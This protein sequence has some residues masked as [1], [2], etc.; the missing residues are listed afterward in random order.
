MPIMTKSIDYIN[1]ILDLA[2]ALPETIRLR[3]LP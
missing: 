3:L 2:A 1:I